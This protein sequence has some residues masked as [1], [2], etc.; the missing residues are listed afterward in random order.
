VQFPEPTAIERLSCKR[1]GSYMTRAGPCASHNGNIYARETSNLAAGVTRLTK[2]RLP[3]IPGAEQGFRDKQKVFIAEHESFINHL[4]RDYDS[5]YAECC[6]ILEEAILH[7]ADPHDK[8]DLRI[9]SWKDIEDYNVL[10]N[11]VWNIP[12]KY[13]LYKVK[14]FEI[15][16]PNKTIRCIGDLGCP[17]SLQGFRLADFTKKA[18]FGEP[19]HINGGTIEFCKEPSVSALTGVFER[20]ISPPGRF[21]FVYFSDDSCLAIRTTSGKILRFNVDI[22]SCDASH[23]AALF[24][25]YVR[26]HPE[27]LQEDARKLVK[28]CEQPI[29]VVDL[30]NRRRKVTLKPKEPR[31]YSGSTITTAINNLACQLIGLAIS[32]TEINC[33]EDVIMAAEKA[34]Y[35]VTCIDCSDWHQ[36]QFLKHSPVFDTDGKL[37]PLLNLGVLLRL[38][39][40]AKGDFIGTKGE[41]LQVKVERQQASLLQGAY[42]RAHFP[43]MESMKECCKGGLTHKL[44]SK[45]EKQLRNASNNRIGLK[46]S[47]KDSDDHFSVCSEEVYKRYLL[48]P[49]EISQMDNDFAHM[50]Y[51]CHY[52]SSATNKIF[53][54]DYDL[55]AKY[56]HGLPAIHLPS[57]PLSRQSC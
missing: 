40:T 4:R 41:S 6:S 47:T 50:G 1:D 36:L 14:I 45:L 39:G 25:A 52:A 28:Q 29:T 10:F 12:G 20:L 2:S 32:E 54:T 7:H 23:T 3:K 30:Y 5:Y 44:T 22:S 51:G 9:V 57:S 13:A 53:K 26:I 33:K 16:K 56:L 17:A 42:P 18:M 15:A 49:H 19:I 21:S 31:L 37:R 46:V 24:D 38:S 8:K 34:G 43:L 48:T 55:N 35:I 11:D 27:R